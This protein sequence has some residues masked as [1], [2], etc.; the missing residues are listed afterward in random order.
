M[1]RVVITILAVVALAGIILWDI[2]LGRR[3]DVSSDFSRATPYFSLLGPPTRVGLENGAQRFFAE[4]VYFDLRLPRWFSHAT[5]EATWT[6]DIRLDDPQ[7]GVS[8]DP[9]DDRLEGKFALYP[10]ARVG[11]E[12]DNVVS[13]VEINLGSLPRSRYGCRL[14]FSVPGADKDTQFF[15]SG[16]T[17][18]AVRGP[19]VDEFRRLIRSYIRGTSPPGI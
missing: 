12:E 17:V 6:K 9:S 2:Q 11:K 10:M 19:L 3:L 13:R 7:L 14:F 1:T 4:P 18:H 16:V 8:L 15:L 5:V